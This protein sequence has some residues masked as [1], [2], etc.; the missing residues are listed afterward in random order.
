[1]DSKEY[2]DQLFNYGT[3]YLEDGLRAWERYLQGF[4]QAAGGEIKLDEAQQRFAEFARKD[5]ADAVRKLMQINYD[6][7]TSLINAYLEF[8]ENALSASV[9]GSKEEITPAVKQEQA[10]SAAPAVKARNIDLHFT[11]KKRSLQKQSFVVANKNGADVD[12]SFEISE[13]ICEDGKTRAV[14]PVTFEPD[15]FV[16]KPGEERIVES[17]LKLGKPLKAG[18]QYIALARVVGFEDLFVRLIVD[19]ASG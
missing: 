7:Y 15:H 17:R 19:P 11:A 5:G 3:R 14:A 4:N 10:I 9:Q 6:Y 16:L 13:L 1:V 12:V 18:L 2:S 8:S